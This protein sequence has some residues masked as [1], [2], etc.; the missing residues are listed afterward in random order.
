MK[1]LNVML[2]MVTIFIISCGSNNGNNTNSGSSSK[3]LSF[4][5]KN[6]SSGVQ[7]KTQ[8][9]IEES[10]IPLLFGSIDVKA[11]QYGHSDT[12]LG[13]RE[14]SDW[15]LWH[16]VRP[17]FAGSTADF[18][19]P[20][21]GSLDV[22]TDL[23]SLGISPSYIDSYGTF[24]IDMLAVRS[25]P[26]PININNSVCG[27][28]YTWSALNTSMFP[29]YHFGVCQHY[30]VVSSVAGL[31]VF[32]LR[33]VFARKDWFPQTIQVYPS[34]GP[35]VGNGGIQ[36][37]CYHTVPAINAF[38][39]EIITSFLLQDYPGATTDG[40]NTVHYDANCPTDGNLPIS[41]IPQSTDVPIVQFTKSKIPN[42]PELTKEGKEIPV[43]DTVVFGSSLEVVVSFNLKPSMIQDYASF[44]IDNNTSPIVLIPAPNGTPWGLNVEFKAISP[45]VQ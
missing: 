15:S 40:I 19:L 32:E 14:P 35:N 45:A 4:K 27:T 11:Y 24:S 25:L 30:H 8:N 12:P 44:N 9:A 21:G 18:I 36:F 26:S 6:G 28:Q 34:T 7:G 43:P 5:Y 1:T 41:I 13:Y 16:I 10:N 39:Q 38:Q 23:Y 31:S 33:V 37:A 2:V 17:G 29:G 20:N 42:Q 3:Y 22:A